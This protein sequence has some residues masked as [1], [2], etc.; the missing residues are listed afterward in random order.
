MIRHIIFDFD[1]TLADTSRGVVLMM[2][3]MLRKIGLPV[4]SEEQ[5]RRQIGLPLKEAVKKGGDVPEHMVEQAVRVYIE[6]FDGVGLRASQLF[7][8]TKEVLRSLHDK[9]ITLSIA[10]SRERRST[11][12]IIGSR[13][14]VGL[15]SCFVS[16]DMGLG[17]KPAPDMVLYIL[18]ELG[19]KKEET[20]VVG[21]TLFDI[22]MG[23]SAGTLTCGVTYGNHTTEMLREAGADFVVDSLSEIL[24]IAGVAK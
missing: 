7:P 24:S 18:R 4:T 11:E 16:A 5:I 20:L 9:G 2:Q 10:T 13:E 6:L 12:M 19:A 15:F 1:G 23:R 8:D 17:A 21:D 22:G 3:Q 14:V